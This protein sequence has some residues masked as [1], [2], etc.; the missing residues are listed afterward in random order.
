[1]ACEPAL[2]HNIA[3]T[4]LASLLAH[5]VNAI[6]CSQQC[7]ALADASPLVRS[8]RPNKPCLLM[9]CCQRGDLRI[10][11]FDFVEDDVRPNVSVDQAP[12]RH[13]VYSVTG[14]M[15]LNCADF[16]RHVGHKNASMT[17]STPPSAGRVPRSYDDPLSWVKLPKMSQGGPRYATSWRRR[18]P[19]GQYPGYPPL[20]E[21]YG[22][23]A[24]L[25]KWSDE[26]TADC[27]PKRAM[28]LDDICG[29]RCP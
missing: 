25:F 5:M 7:A 27:P 8:R 6:D 24:K 29:G 11:C 13:H 3:M 10:S 28:N 16:Q 9:S 19:A 2:C 15:R 20:I 17:L 18:D 26:I 21:R 23:D 22:I 12:V 1:M 14:R 4:F